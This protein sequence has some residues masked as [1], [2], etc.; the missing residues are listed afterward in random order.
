[1]PFDRCCKAAEHEQCAHGT[2]VLCVRTEA[3]LCS[4][5]HALQDVKDPLRRI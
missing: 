2:I 1:M 3:L 5:V 4:V